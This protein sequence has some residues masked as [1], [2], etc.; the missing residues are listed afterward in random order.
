MTA[1]S[2]VKVEKNVDG[3]DKLDNVKMENEGLSDYNLL[4]EGDDVLKNN[5]CEEDADGSV[6]ATA[7]NRMPGHTGFLTFATKL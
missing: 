6:T 5:N 7:L 1:E 2:D 3:A 4:N